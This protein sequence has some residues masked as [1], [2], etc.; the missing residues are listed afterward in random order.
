MSPRALAAHALTGFRF[1]KDMPV[2]AE[3]GG[4]PAIW[5]ALTGINAAGVLAAGQTDRAD[6]SGHPQGSNNASVGG[7]I[8]AGGGLGSVDVGNLT[9]MSLA[10]I[11]SVAPAFQ[12]AMMGMLPGYNS[13]LGGVSGGLQRQQQQ[14]QLQLAA[15]VA[16]MQ[17]AG[18]SAQAQQAPQ[19][20]QQEQQQ[21]QP[22][23]EAP[24]FPPPQ[25]ASLQAAAPPPKPQHESHQE[26]P[27]VTT[28]TVTV[29]ASGA[30]P[31]VSASAPTT[32]VIAPALADATLDHNVF[33]RSP[34]STLPIATPQQAAAEEATVAA[35]AAAAVAAEN[36][37]L[38]HS[39]VAQQDT[40]LS[41][42]A[43][44]LAT[45]EMAG[46]V[47]PTTE[48]AGAGAAPAQ[49]FSPKST[50]DGLNLLAMSQELQEAVDSARSGAM[51]GA[52]LSP[53]FSRGGAGVDFG[54]GLVGG[55]AENGA[56][57]PMQAKFSTTSKPQSKLRR[58]CD[59]CTMRKIRCDG[60]GIICKRCVPGL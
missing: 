55:D 3:G 41:P 19:Q 35:A 12:L 5:P 39:V 10:Q 48:G 8:M 18:S 17:T 21:Q 53:S 47:T 36:A 2:T 50:S 59:R 33:T 60:T 4:N 34:S 25:S 9:P 20:Q 23:K 29:A 56:P 13:V 42:S 14:Q 7:G 6:A 31:P 38:A 57:S 24:V 58:S 32:A 51:V 15:A 11:A 37:A 22:L 49:I 16:A 54:E 1:T 44:P 46:T 27:G 52:E 43:L 28:A 30:Q 26:G 40:L 45:P